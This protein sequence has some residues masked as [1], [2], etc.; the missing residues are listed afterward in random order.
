MH[1]GR[2]RDGKRER[3]RDGEKGREGERESKRGRERVRERED[4]A[5]DDGGGEDGHDVG[6][7]PGDALRHPHQHPRPRLVVPLSRRRG[8]SALYGRVPRGGPVPCRI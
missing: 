8:P 2:E 7:E 6:R 3:E 1:G 4:L 5:L